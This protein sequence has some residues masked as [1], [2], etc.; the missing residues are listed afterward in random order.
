LKLNVRPSAKRGTFSTIFSSSSASFHPTTNHPTQQK[1]PNM[2]KAPIPSSSSSTS[3]KRKIQD[4]KVLDPK[5][6]PKKPR[7]LQKKSSKSQLK[8]APEKKDDGPSAKEIPAATSFAQLSLPLA[9]HDTVSRLNGTP[10]L[11]PLQRQAIPALLHGRD[12][13]APSISVRSFF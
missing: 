6:G 7:T 2:T 12:V 13:S 9:L 11:S 4:T 1:P 10:E 8:A 3:K 5:T